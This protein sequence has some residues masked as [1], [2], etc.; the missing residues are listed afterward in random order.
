MLSSRLFY[1]ATRA[2]GESSFVWLGNVFYYFLRVGQRM[3]H[4]EKN[5]VARA[6]NRARSIP[7]PRAREVK[8]ALDGASENG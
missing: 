5:R 6:T 1:Y 8:R 2:P 7:K 3:S 4:L